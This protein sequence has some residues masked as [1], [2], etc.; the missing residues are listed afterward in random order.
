MTM[1]IFSSH[2]KQ[3][4][5]I[6]RQLFNHVDFVAQIGKVLRNP[7][8]ISNHLVQIVVVYSTNNERQGVTAI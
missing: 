3:F 4:H 7:E 6:Y 8:I 5:W 1:A 2:N